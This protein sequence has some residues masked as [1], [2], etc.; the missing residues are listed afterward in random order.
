MDETEANERRI[1]QEGSRGELGGQ[2]YR[3]EQESRD[4]QEF[5]EGRELARGA[6]NV[7]ETG[8]E[9]GVASQDSLQ[10][11][12]EAA[13]RGHGKFERGGLTESA[14]GVEREM[15]EV[16]TAIE[17]PLSQVGEETKLLRREREM[18]D[19]EDFRAEE[20]LPPK[21]AS[22]DQIALVHRDHRIVEKTQTEVASGVAEEVKK[23]MNQSRVAP[24]DLDKIR[25][26]GMYRMLSGAFGYKFGS[27]N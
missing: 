7:A 9:K 4:E 6:G 25:N 2:E 21:N 26:E 14:T 24:A 5:R 8:R 22:A 23:I 11:L 3:A 17:R 10:R 16:E 18:A 12:G 1:T 27:G 19:R 15:A 13:L 20:D